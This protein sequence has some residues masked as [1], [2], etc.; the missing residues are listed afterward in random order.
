[1]GYG[2]MGYGLEVMGL[3]VMGLGGGL[4]LA[5]TEASCHPD[6]VKDPAQGLCPITQLY[7]NASDDTRL[8]LNSLRTSSLSR[9]SGRNTILWPLM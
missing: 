6:E 7:A 1:M 3:R 8:S 5:L 2:V 9:G 4:H